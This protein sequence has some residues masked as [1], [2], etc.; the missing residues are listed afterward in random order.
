MLT[1]FFDRAVYYSILGH[2][3][4]VTIPQGETRDT[5]KNKLFL[6]RKDWYALLGMVQLDCI[7]ILLKQTRVRF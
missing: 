3:E 6:S 1:Q 2:D 7:K 5:Q 4:A